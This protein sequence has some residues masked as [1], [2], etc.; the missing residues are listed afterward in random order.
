MYNINI[1]SKT[2]VNIINVFV[3]KIFELAVIYYILYYMQ[4]KSF[5]INILVQNLR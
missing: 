5:I 1:K 2:N 3:D 4:I